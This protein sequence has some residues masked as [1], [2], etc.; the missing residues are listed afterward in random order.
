MK[1]ESKNKALEIW[2]KAGFIERYKCPKNKELRAYLS[3]VW[4]GILLGLLSALLMGL[5]LILFLK[6]V[7]HG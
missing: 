4:S 5:L 2:A 1:E 6:G 3:G 7:P